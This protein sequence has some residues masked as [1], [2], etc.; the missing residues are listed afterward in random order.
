MEGRT[1]SLEFEV[2]QGWDY[3]RHL[4]AA[5]ISSMCKATRPDQIITLKRDGKKVDLS[6]FEK[7]QLEDFNEA[8][9]EELLEEGEEVK[10]ISMSE[11]MQQ[12][13]NKAE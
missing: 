12:L 7:Q 11:L 3:T 8:L 4:M 6:G 13:K 2:E 1:Q 9:D 10:I 5:V